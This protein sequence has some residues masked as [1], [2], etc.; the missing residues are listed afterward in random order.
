MVAQHG[1]CDEAPRQA[2]NNVKEKPGSDITQGR[3]SKRL[4]DVVLSLV[5][6]IASH[7]AAKN[8]TEE[9]DTRTNLDDVIEL[10]G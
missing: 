10:I 5:C 3:Q 6:C 4:L 8:V 1:R 9:D 7:K 2:H